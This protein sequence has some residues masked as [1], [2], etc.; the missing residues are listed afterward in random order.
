M[1]MPQVYRPIPR[2]AFEITP[3][4]A[5]SS[6]PPSPASE[7]V[8]NELLAGQKSDSTPSRTRS[9]LNLTSSTLLG[10]YS[11]ISDGNKEELSTPWGTGAQTPI[12]E[13]RSVD[14]SIPQEPSLS[15]PRDA[16]KP[17]LKQ[18]RKDVISILF[19]TI[20]LFAFGIGYGSIVT[21]LHKTQRI[22][23]V[24]VP[25]VE[26]SSLW[27]LVSWG[28]FGIVLGNALPLVDAFWETTVATAMKGDPATRNR[29][30]DAAPTT[31]SDNTT[32]SDSGL[33][34]MWYSAVRSVGVFVG[35]AFA[36]RRLP[37]QS[38]LQ[39]ALT[40]A[41]A[42]PV[43]WYLIDRS[44]PGFA[45]SAMVSIA[46]TLA[47]LLV[48]PNF[49]PVPAIH[50]QMASEQFGVY[51]WLASILFCTSICFGAIGRRLQL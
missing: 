33:G 31:T 50:Q 8:N 15:W 25:D 34:P 22:T 12:Q 39:V 47:L 17:R 6:M 16:T 43:L 7:A 18:K 21:H 45:L 38:T 2:R 14:D 3:A 32:A 1:E 40:L 28:V 11:P 30:S 37:W 9:I 48:D 44:L 51:T 4:S 35:I 29:K 36:V 19:Q 49:V 10:I 13:R 41:L 24:P 20:L 26:R 46:G 27:Y 23:P 42:N 5:D